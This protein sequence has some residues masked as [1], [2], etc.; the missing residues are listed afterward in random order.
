[1]G[2]I[3]VFL[4]IF[5]ASSS[6]ADPLRV[7]WW[8]NPPFY[9]AEPGAPEPVGA[10]VD[11]V[12]YLAAQTGRS[13]AFVQVATA[14]A[15]QIAVA[16]GQ[17][18]LALDL[19]G[20]FDLEDGLVWSQP[21]YWQKYQRFVR[22]DASSEPEGVWGAVAPLPR[23]LLAELGPPE[24]IEYFADTKTALEA[25]SQG[26]VARAILPQDLAR[27]ELRRLGLSR[28][29]ASR[30]PPKASL[31]RHVVISASH[32]PLAAALELSIEIA[33]QTGRIDDTL[34]RHGLGPKERAGQPVTIGLSSASSVLGPAEQA[35]LD[36]LIMALERQA[37]WVL[38]VLPDGSGQVDGWVEIGPAAQG[39][40]LFGLTVFHA[41]SNH[42]DSA[43][44]PFAVLR[45]MAAVL[46]DDDAYLV[47]DTVP[48]LL[49][50]VMAGRARGVVAS[51]ASLE[52]FNRFGAALT[53]S[54]DPVTVLPLT[55]RFA[56]PRADLAAAADLALTDLRMAGFVHQEAQASAPM[57]QASLWLAALVGLGGVAAWVWGGKL[58]RMARAR[59][60]QARLLQHSQDALMAWSTE[61]GLTVWNAG[62]QALYGFSAPAVLGRQP[63][64]FLQSRVLMA[65]PGGDELVWHRTKAR[66][67][68]LVRRRR[69][70]LSLN[71]V[72]VMLDS[73]R[74]ASRDVRLDALEE[75]NATLSR[76]E[77]EL[78]AANRDLAAFAHAA[79]HDLKAPVNTQLLLIEEM[80][81]LT[82]CR[83]DPE[84]AELLADMEFT[85]VD[86]QRMISTVMTL[87][88]PQSDTAPQDQLRL[89]DVLDE[90][91]RAMRADLIDSG[92]RLQNDGLP[93]LRARHGDMRHLLQNLI[94]NA[95]KFRH[96]ERPLVIHLK[97]A[98]AP[99]GQI[100][101]VVADNGLG[102]SGSEQ[103]E[104]LKPFA[105][106]HAGTPG[107]GL[108]LAL[109]QRIV[110]AYDGTITLS[111][112][113]SQG[114]IVTVLLQE[115]QHDRQ[116]AARG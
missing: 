114:L 51:A 57:S 109:C 60:L 47:V 42:A 11:L 58:V 87:S 6:A 53:W 88:H 59:R 86:M 1:M 41:V 15:A 84:I 17:V 49:E 63:D 67:D 107:H 50:T 20:G 75:L 56:R 54:E 40:H 24:K 31:P 98:D 115:A 116:F 76:R 104:M 66:T 90:V 78:A 99:P 25:L 29:I 13:A 33:R 112:P 32:P 39:I 8:Q 34:H 2:R 74:D 97:P 102:L 92:A 64:S 101:F 69:Q 73:C 91:V 36:R 7:A 14:D 81:H 79:S 35:D 103:S 37:G 3:L 28:K 65:D 82:G 55:L 70:S 93:I 12:R 27:Y 26:S 43:G 16:R 21:F 89:D 23:A 106:A 100:G 105:R 72:T 9:S 95:I 94:E 18:D 19:A 62:A 111:G 38:R 52:R 113:Q 30:G 44:L 22:R 10:W 71:G 85:A 5:A 61:T 108:G 68:I 83:E 46:P 4:V 110:N 48:A 45:S 96:P 80:R 77:T